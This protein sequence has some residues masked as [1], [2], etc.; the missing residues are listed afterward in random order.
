MNNPE[1]EDANP[2]GGGSRRLPDNADPAVDYTLAS[3]R[4]GTLRGSACLLIQTHQAQRVVYGRRHSPG[5]PGIVGLVR[6]G[7]MV[8]R[9]WQAAAADDPWADWCLLRLH[10]ALEG[11]RDTL[12]VMRHQVDELLAGA[13]GVEIDIAESAQP[14]RVPLQFTSPYAYM[15]AY[16]VHDLDEIIRAALTARHVGLMTRDSMERQIREGVRVVRRTFL[17]PREWVYCAVTRND[18]RQNNARARKAAGVMGELP[19]DVLDMTRR[20]PHAPII[21]AGSTAGAAGSGGIQ[22]AGA[23][24]KSGIG[25]GDCEVET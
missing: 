7:L 6:F 23:A 16:L 24:E 22:E 2:P 17:M 15:G 14:V 25:N 4:P 10:E 18:V 20:A 19:Q 3:D 11:A 13:G 8:R 5:Q 1:K 9:V 12:G 21:R